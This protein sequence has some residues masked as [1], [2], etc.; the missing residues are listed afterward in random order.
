MWWVRSSRNKVGEGNEMRKSFVQQWLYPD[1]SLVLFCIVFVRSYL[2]EPVLF[3]LD[4]DIPY[5]FYIY[6]MYNVIH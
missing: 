2:L 4:G 1:I 6:Y 3:T 5:P